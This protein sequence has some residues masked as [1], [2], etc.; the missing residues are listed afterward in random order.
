MNR[1]L[2]LVRTPPPA[3][4]FYADADQ[5]DDPVPDVRIRDTLVT[6]LW[7]MRWYIAAAIAV[8]GVIDLVLWLG[9]RIQ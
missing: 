7:L 2:F 6:V 5:Q 9:W 4:P 8:A 3:K 1:P